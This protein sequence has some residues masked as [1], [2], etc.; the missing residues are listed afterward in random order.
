VNAVAP[1][2]VRT[3][4]SRSVWA[5]NEE[6]LAGMTPLGRI[7]EPSDIAPTVAF[8]CSDAAAWITGE[9]LVVDG[10]ESLGSFD[11]ATPS[12]SDI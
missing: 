7:G 4:M 9:T 6:A 8:L 5:G 2:I 12:S 3:E 10:G 1:G 11:A